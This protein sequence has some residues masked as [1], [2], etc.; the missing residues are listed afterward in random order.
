M[1]WKASEDLDEDKKQGE[2]GQPQATAGQVLS[3]PSAS[4][5][6][7]QA[8]SST[9]TPQS[10][11]SSGSFTNL[12]S[13]IGANTGAD[14]AMVGRVGNTVTNAK[15]T[16]T[17]SG[18]TLQDNAAKTISEN[19]ITD[20]TG[21][22]DAVKSA[23]TLPTVNPDAQRSRP[24]APAPTTNTKQPRGPLTPTQQEP[25]GPRQPTYAPPPPS[26]PT[27]KKLD[28]VTTDEFGKLY[29]AEWKGPEDASRVDGHTDAKQA[30]GKVG[31]YGQLL[32]GDSS[33]R[34]VVL[35]DTFATSGQQYTKGERMLDS[36]LLGAG[37]EAGAVQQM[38]ENATSF[39][40]GF[41]GIEALINDNIKQGMD[42]TDA[43]KKAIR[44]AVHGAEGSAGT[45]SSIEGRLSDASTLATNKAA[46]DTATIAAAQAGDKAALKRLGYS[47]ADIN[48]MLYIA[49]KGGDLKQFISGTASYGIG[50]TADSQDI[51]NY[52]S[53]MALLGGAG[54]DVDTKFSDLSAGG[55]LSVNTAGSL[56]D[57]AGL[58][59]ALQ[60]VDGRKTQF[61]DATK[62]AS[63][64]GNTGY[65]REPT[66]NELQTL[67]SY[68]GIPAADLRDAYYLGIDIMPMLAPG[69]MEL[70]LP[71]NNTSEIESLAKLLG[72]EAKNAG[73]HGNAPV[74]FNADAFNQAL[75][76]ARLEWNPITGV[77][78]GGLGPTNAATINN[79]KD[80]LIL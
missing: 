23:A 8:A 57:L 54:A 21:V 39:A 19:T 3:S 32:S 7:G 46:T 75:A 70:Y 55:G 59:G 80:V 69:N 78:G 29:N 37:S 1:V 62:V 9:T 47:D 53:L 26:T 27:G 38:A 66:A 2:E 48:N 40:G 61:D 45:L 43:T 51:T 6:T 20:T 16:A 71:M 33:D 77:A 41:E 30:F 52:Q 79:T 68:T 28:D 15:D 72:I 42:T 49:S 34:G 12:Q 24:A 35:D 10:Q 63:L 67:S 73:T 13:Y 5:N 56:G 76:K 36:Y 14:K 58:A 50:D 74:V 65:G 4:G 25:S 64:F 60:T 11:R 31:Q 17:T 22:T 18:Q 44:D